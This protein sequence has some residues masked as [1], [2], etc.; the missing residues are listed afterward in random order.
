MLL[1]RIV[2]PV[3]LEGVMPVGKKEKIRAKMLTG[4][5]DLIY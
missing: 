1:C 4:L 2:F 3:L 5:L